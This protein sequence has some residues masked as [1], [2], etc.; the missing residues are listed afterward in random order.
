MTDQPTA[1]LGVVLAVQTN[2]V[3]VAS[4][5]QPVGSSPAKRQQLPSRQVH[6]LCP[7]PPGVPAPDRPG[8][9][10]WQLDSAS[11][12]QA[13]PPLRE[14]SAAWILLQEASGETALPLM[15]WIELVTADPTPAAIAASWL[16]LQGPQLLYRQ[17]QQL[18]EARPVAELRRLRQD[19]HR[20]RLQEHHRQAWLRSL[21][22]RQPLDRQ[23]LG[24]EE[25]A[26]LDVLVAWASGDADQ[27]VSVDLRQAL[28]KA[29]CPLERGAIRHL[30]VDL[31]QWD[32]HQLPTLR[33][34]SWELGFSD[35]IETEAQQLLAMAEQEQPGDRERLDLTHLW[36]VTIDDSTTLE[37]DDGLSL[38]TTAEGGQRLWIHVADPGRLVVE[39]T[40][41]DLEARRRATSL[42]LAQGTLPMFPV[43]LSHGPFS[44]RSG[45]RN[46][47]WSIWVEL[48]GEGGV[49][50]SGLQRSWIQ[51]TYRLTYE[52]ADDLI[53]LAPPQEAQLAGMHA[54]MERRRQWRERQGA[55]VMDQGEG[56]MRVRDGQVELEITEPGLSRSMVAEAMILA[57]A[58]VADFGHRHG[59]ALPYRSQLPAALPSD[60]ELEVLPVGPV[61]HAALKRCLSRGITGTEPARHFSLGLE[62]YVQATS[63]IRRYGDL[64]VQR[65]LA[66]H[67][68]GF[69]PKEAPALLELLQELESGTRQAAAISRED[70]RHWQQVWF[71][72]H[73]HAPWPAV[74]LRW[75][76]P[77]DHL[78]LVHVETLAMDLAA[79]CPPGA[80]PGDALIL[81][82]SAV[83]PLSDLLQLRA[84]L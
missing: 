5:I 60:A 64:L 20:Q 74:F 84:T 75:L 73:R 81:R 3:S 54:L 56:R 18:V 28:Q 23:S 65:Q 19:R 57:G 1:R 40:P 17:R 30:L 4:G 38:E 47:A 71:E 70:Q 51:P 43:A 63:P 44:L 37:L 41:L 50:A 69:P 2:K 79:T 72:A 9:F 53:E 77:Q 31:G 26:D 55:L 7:L 52:D 49:T 15:E 67:L 58:V 82:V 22:Q 29:G 16:W 48:D 27:P 25:R 21:Q 45:H 68:S 8:A 11:L 80:D 59:L 46:A 13:L 10:P 33:Q 32:P 83:D 42:Y 36:A 76:R 35:A 62:A 14:L 78:G 61:R 34:S 12:K 66:A 24:P 6:L 39:G